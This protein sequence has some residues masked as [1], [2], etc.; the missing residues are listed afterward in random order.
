MTVKVFPSIL[1]NL[2]SN[3]IYFNASL[4]FLFTVDIMTFLYADLL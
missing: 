4:C 1:S 2:K 3:V